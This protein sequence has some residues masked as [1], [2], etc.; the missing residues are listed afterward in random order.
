MSGLF[1]SD[2]LY[3]TLFTGC[4]FLF[5][6]NSLKA[7]LPSLTP[8]PIAYSDIEMSGELALRAEK[9]YDRLESSIYTPSK[10]FPVLN[11]NVPVEWPGDV[12]GR[13]ILGLVLEA[14][15]THRKPKYLDEIIRMLPANLNKQG[16]FGPLQKDTV[17]EQQLSGNGWYLRALC[18]YYRW[19]KDPK[20]KGY[21]AKVIHHLALPTK[22]KHGIYPIDPSSRNRTVG[23]A[24]G[25]TQATVGK[26]RLSSD[27]GCDFIFMDGV[28]Q[29]Y[30][31]VP[32]AALKS[33]IDEMIGR[34]LQM[35]MKAINAQTHA[36]LTG[37]RSLLRY[38]VLT[39]KTTLLKELR[40][41]YNLYRSSAMT[42]NF[43]NFNWFGRP[44][45]TEPCAIVD[46]YM[47]AVQ[48]WQLTADPMYLED[49]HHIYFNAIANTQRAN[50]GFGLSNCTRPNFNS[51]RVDI[52]EAS[53]CCTMRGAEGLAAAVKYSYF[54][55][56]NELIVPFFNSS[57]ANIKYNNG[58]VSIRQT[59]AYPF[60]GEVKFEVLSSSLNAILKIKLL[61]PSW[62]S[63]HQLKVNGTA[64]PFRIE[65][66]FIVFEKKM[67]KGDQITLS[68]SQEV[69]PQKMLNKEYSLPGF[70]T[71]NYGPLV[72]GYHTTQSGETSFSTIPEFARISKTD[73]I[74][75]DTD[76]HLSPV[77]HLLDPG[78]TKE[79]GDAKQ[80]LFKIAG[81]R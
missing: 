75:K 64:V 73:W 12:E 21:I 79:S 9:N 71:L 11:K 63:N 22:G 49:A 6:T 16:Y 52:D 25:T 66:G 28:V 15:A 17:N 65:K 57:T 74:V 76:I 19:K 53:W 46:S 59:S 77:Y 61:A 2:M 44:E 67:R 48:M 39:K 41:R 42:A 24:S 68:F 62:T 7:Q 20:I 36:S 51:L 60:Q 23:A 33:L 70:Y 50:G 4:F 13:I 78:V 10:I 8:Q 3:R 35:D 69:H 26:W 80:I 31:V 37:L 1:L 72:L 47:L 81:Q 40:Q 45:W 30:E 56:R 29:S 34:F 5:F 18:E 14:Q 27:I 58:S 43:E 32:S 38:Y 55:H 54:R